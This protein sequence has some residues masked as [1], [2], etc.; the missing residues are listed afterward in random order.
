MTGNGSKEF[1]YDLEETIID[2]PIPIETEHLE[3]I[4]AGYAQID[5]GTPVF[6]SNIV[7]KL[8][9]RGIENIPIEKIVE[10][11]KN[12]KRATN[13]QQGGYG[14]FE[15]TEKHIHNELHHGRIGFPELCTVAEN[16][17]AS[18]IGSNEFQLE[19]ENF[20]LKQYSADNL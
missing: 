3:K 12:L 13:I 18:N 9:S 16:I 8:I 7:E 17:F 1:Y 4:L 5:Q 10:I 6:Y 15:V 11:C 19:I 14:F 2:S 20:L